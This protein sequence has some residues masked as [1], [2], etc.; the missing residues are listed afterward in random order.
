MF[1]NLGGAKDNGLYLGLAR[2]ETGL[3]KPSVSA[4]PL[5]G[6]LIGDFPIGRSQQMRKGLI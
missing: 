6:K 1:I 5:V 2:R 4:I 3:A